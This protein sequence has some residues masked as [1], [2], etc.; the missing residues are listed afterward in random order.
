MLG[1]ELEVSGI[2]PFIDGRA[3]AFT[4]EPFVVGNR[5][6]DHSSLDPEKMINKYSFDYVV[7][8][9]S[10]PMMIYILH[11]PDRFKLIYRED[12]SF[13]DKEFQKEALSLYKIVH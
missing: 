8:Y 2:K 9:Q 12:P 4:G 1:N 13:F 6:L 11:S 5:H 3:D 10:D 7:L